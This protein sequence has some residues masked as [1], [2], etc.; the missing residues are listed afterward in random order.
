MRIEI[1]KEWSCDTKT[2]RVS[3]YVEI[4]DEPVDPMSQIPK[5]RDQ[6]AE[7][8][9]IAKALSDALQNP[10]TVCADQS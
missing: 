2:I 4:N 5:I 10:E 6:P 9:R 3:G 1:I 7:I 8:Q